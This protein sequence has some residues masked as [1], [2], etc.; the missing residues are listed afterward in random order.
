MRSTI[1]DPPGPRYRFR[2]GLER[3]MIAIRSLRL[4]TPR[5]AGQADRLSDRGAS[6]RKILAPVRGFTPA[7]EDT[8][9][10]RAS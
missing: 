5:Q 9:G 7:R 4:K 3:E 8:R 1:V 6:V 2:R 10:S